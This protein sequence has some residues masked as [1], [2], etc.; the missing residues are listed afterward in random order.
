[1]LGN[2]EGENAGPVAGGVKRSHCIGRR[3]ICGDL[4]FEHLSPRARGRGDVTVEDFAEAFLKTPEFQ[5]LEESRQFLLVDLAHGEFVDR[6]GQ[7]HIPQQS[8]HLDVVAHVGFVRV[9]VLTQ[10]GSQVVE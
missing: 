2:R 5:E 6:Q 9:E 8:H 1:M 4:G 10:F 7:L 3:L